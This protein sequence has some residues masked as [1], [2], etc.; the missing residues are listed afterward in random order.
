METTTRPARPRLGNPGHRDDVRFVL[1]DLFANRADVRETKM[2]SFPSFSTGGKMF[3]VVIGDGVG[4]KLPQETIDRLADDDITPFEPMGKKMSSWIQISRPDAE[5][6]R[7]DADL[8]EVAISY[9]D[10]LAAT[11]E[12][13]R[14]S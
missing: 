7:D 1:S 3:A 2:F 11:Q 4:V 10:S 8:F 6:Y 13:P 14:R 9:V 5:M 12:K